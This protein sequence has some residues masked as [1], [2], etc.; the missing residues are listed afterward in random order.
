MSQRCTYQV[1]NAAMHA[2]CSPL[3]LLQQQVDLAIHVHCQ[4]QGC[5]PLT[6]MLNADLRTGCTGATRFKGFGSRAPQ[7]LVMATGD[8]TLCSQHK[9]MTLCS[10]NHMLSPVASEAAFKHVAMQEVRIG[11]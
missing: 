10:P 11:C 4:A 5:V 8:S 6:S 3:Q 2:V 9:R 7:H 1:V